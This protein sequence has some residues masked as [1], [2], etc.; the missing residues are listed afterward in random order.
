MQG[1]AT[2]LAGAIRDARG[3]RTQREAF[4]ALGVTERTYR[5]WE[6]GESVPQGENIDAL[7]A[8]GVSRELF[9]YAPAGN[10]ER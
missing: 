8:F 10:S 6:A 4:Q 5:R 1:A 3:N 7:I 2:P 9:T